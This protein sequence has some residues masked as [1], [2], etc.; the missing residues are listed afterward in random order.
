M[1]HGIQT[2]PPDAEQFRC[3]DTMPLASFARVLSDFHRTLQRQSRELVTAQAREGESV[4]RQR[5]GK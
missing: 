1:E 3:V 5:F 2:L 4:R